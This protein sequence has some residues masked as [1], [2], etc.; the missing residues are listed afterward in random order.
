M[1]LTFDAAAWAPFVPLAGLSLQARV[2]TG[3]GKARGE[4]LEDLL[5][6]HRGLSGPAILQ[7][8]TYWRP[9]TPI[10]LDLA[11]ADDLGE[12]LVA[13]KNASRRKLAN[14]LADLLPRRLAETWLAPR[15]EL[16]DRPLPEIRDRDL[17]QLEIGRAHV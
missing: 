13:A 4:F 5:F 17:Q 7:I 15:A 11:P 10:R 3:N 2:Q 1:P 6:T 12:R 9:G 16:A 14:E 8:S